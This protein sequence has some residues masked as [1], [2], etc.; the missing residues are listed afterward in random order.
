MFVGSFGPRIKLHMF[1]VPVMY[2]WCALVC[3]KRSLRQPGTTLGGHYIIA[4]DARP[5]SIDRMTSA[6]VIPSI[7]S[8][9]G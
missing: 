5:V 7:A 8:V 6:H 1:G 2:P 3:L 9:K 4:D